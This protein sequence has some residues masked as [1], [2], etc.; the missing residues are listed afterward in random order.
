MS[1][2]REQW[3][4]AVI[5]VMGRLPYTIP[6]PADR[7]QPDETG[8]GYLSRQVGDDDGETVQG[9]YDDMTTDEELI[10]AN[11]VRYTPDIMAMLVCSAMLGA[12]KMEPR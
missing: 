8:F 7:K 2:K 9:T 5:E 3:C 6:D 12:G 4:L 11:T 1:H 10:E